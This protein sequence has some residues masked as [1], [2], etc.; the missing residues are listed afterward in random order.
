MRWN[1]VSSFRIL[2]HY[3]EDTGSINLCY[4]NTVAAMWRQF[5]ANLGKPVFKRFHI[6]IKIARLDSLVFPIL[7]FRFSR[8]P[9]SK[10]RAKS[11]D[12]VQR[13]MISICLGLRCLVNESGESFVQR[14]LARINE[15][16][17]FQKRWS[18]IWASRVV[19]WS[20]HVVRNTHG[21]CWSTQLIDVV[22]PEE[23]AER[24]RD[25][26]NRPCTRIVPGFTST[27]WY[28]SIEPA[29]EWILSLNSR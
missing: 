4:S 18:Y 29:N 6:K 9:F 14:R 20:N 10:S 8:W 12:R 13:K 23:L 17:P 25:N 27:R 21:H 15:I 19:D 2:G 16:I 24:R 1:V 28:E 26:Y 5:W 3:I 22:S 7:N 11:L